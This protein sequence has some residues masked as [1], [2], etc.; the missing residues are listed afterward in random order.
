MLEVIE[1]T[2]LCHLIQSP[3]AL[4]LRT[5]LIPRSGRRRLRVNSAKNLLYSLFNETQQMLRCVQHDGRSFS[6]NRSQCAASVD[7]GSSARLE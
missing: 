1:K 3:F 7:F 4:H 5:A 2:R 6:T